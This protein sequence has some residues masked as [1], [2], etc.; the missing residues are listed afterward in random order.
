MR[1]RLSRVIPATCGERR[2][3][4]RKNNGEPGDR[5]SSS[6]TS[7]AAPPNLPFSNASISAPS[8]TTGHREILISQSAG[9]IKLKRFESMRPVV[10]SAN[11]H[12]RTTTS[13]WARASQSDELENGLEPDAIERRQHR[14]TT[15]NK[16]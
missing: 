2:T 14:T 16:N 12:A 8:S 9:F 13:D 6:N 11:G 3:L 1:P 5:G 15:T 7:S 4:G 10:C